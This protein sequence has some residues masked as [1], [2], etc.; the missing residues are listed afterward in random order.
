MTKNGILLVTIIFFLTAIQAQAITLG[1]VTGNDYMKMDNDA[2]LA[3]VIGAMDG[4]MAESFAHKKDDKG[5]WLGRCVDGLTTHQIKAMFEK[6]LGNNPEAWHAP[7][8]LVFRGKMKKICKGR[9]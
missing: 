6:E 7:G 2:R 1:Y 3:W 8:A 4:I 5:P 9:I